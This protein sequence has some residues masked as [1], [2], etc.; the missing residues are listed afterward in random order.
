MMNLVEKI[1]AAHCGKTQVSPGDFINAKVDLVLAN[2]ITAPI[3]IK[4]FKKVGISKV[5][6]SKKIVFVP[7]HFVPNK[8]IASAEQVKMVREF[9]REQG[10]LFFECGKMGVEHV[11]LH[12]QGLVLPGDIV[13]GADSHTCTY[14]ALGA[15]TTGMGSTDIAAAM[16]TGEV[17]MKVPQTIKFNY[18]GKLP[19]WIGGKDLILYTIGQ[20]GVDGAL[21]SAMFFCGEAIEALS[22]ENRFTMSNMA[23]EAGGKAGLFRVDEKTLEYVTPRAKRQYTV[24]D[25]DAD[26]SYA[27][28]YNFDISKIE[29]QV[30][31]PHSPA[32][33]RPVSQIGKIKVDQVIIGSCTNGRL[34]DLAVSAKLLKGNVVHPDLRTIV[35]PGSQQVYLDALKAG[36]IETFINA[37]VAVSTPT[38]GPCLGGHMGILAAG[39][40]CLATTNRN[41]VGRMGSPKS[42][43]Y[44][45]G[46]AVAAATAIKGYIA[47]PDEI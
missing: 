45:A 20:T 29:P 23:I 27:K 30:S 3:A 25:N 33:A 8:D 14:G 22:M 36:Y 2:D 12:E 13:V 47:H 26:A 17:W 39:E 41:F 43:V 15:F 24:Y 28:T 37:G 21:Y 16:A 6:D 44:L 35:I 1:L 4:E 10:I 38:C 31:L 40:R 32:N 11:I 34:E 42:E 7:D 19:K 5:F 18:S 9:A 46:P